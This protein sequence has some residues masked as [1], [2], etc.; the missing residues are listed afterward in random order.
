M[1]PLTKNFRKF[2]IYKDQIYH[3]ISN[4]IWKDLSIY[5]IKNNQIKIK[6]MKIISI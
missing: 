4:W 2:K 1:F 5:L 6:M 3:K